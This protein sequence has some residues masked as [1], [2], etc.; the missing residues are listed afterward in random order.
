MA[1]KTYKVTYEAELVSDGNLSSTWVHDVIVKAVRENSYGGYI[2]TN[3]NTR[4]EQ[5]GG[6][7]E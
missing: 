3:D 4:I 7:D 2:V 1:F 5:T 6:D